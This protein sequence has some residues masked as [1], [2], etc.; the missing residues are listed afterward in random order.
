MIAGR[1]ALDYYSPIWPVGDTVGANTNRRYLNKSVHLFILSK[2]LYHQLY[3]PEH[4][5]HHRF[6]GVSTV[7][8]FGTLPNLSSFTSGL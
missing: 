4:K 2:G 8:D 3:E 6:G 1:V 5:A 7:D